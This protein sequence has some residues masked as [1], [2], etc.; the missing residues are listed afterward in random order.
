MK[1]SETEKCQQ[2]CIIT[3]DG[4]HACGCD[5]GFILAKDNRTCEDVDEC[6]FQKVRLLNI[7]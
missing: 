7:N 3:S 6:K 5:P 4:K 2:H 1:C